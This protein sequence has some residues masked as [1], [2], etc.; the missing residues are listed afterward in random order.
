MPTQG[1]VLTRAGYGTTKTHNCTSAYTG[2]NG[3]YEVAV[4]YTGGNFY[5]AYWLFQP[6]PNAAKIISAR[7][8][9][10]RSAFYTSGTGFDVRLGAWTN[11]YWA[12]SFTLTGTLTTATEKPVIRTNESMSG[13]SQWKTIELDAAA[14]NI[15]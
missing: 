8:R 14:I 9:F 2:S 3:N 5:A 4:G 10:Y 7:I 6:I 11:D 12:S 15:L 13:A 1:S